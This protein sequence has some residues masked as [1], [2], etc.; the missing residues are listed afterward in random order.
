VRVTVTAIALGQP[1]LSPSGF[2]DVLLGGRE[3]EREVEF[4]HGFSSLHAKRTRHRPSFAPA[5]VDGGLIR[6]LG[7]WSTRL[8]DARQLGLK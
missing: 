1:F 7:C 6:R 4:Q 3:I 8:S 5:E 2:S